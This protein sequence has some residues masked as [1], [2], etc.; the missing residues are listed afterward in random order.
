MYELFRGPVDD[1]NQ[2]CL[3]GSAQS[4][5]HCFHL[6]YIARAVGHED[7][8]REN[9]RMAAESGSYTHVASLADDAR[10]P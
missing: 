1:I 2:V 6:G 9:L 8:A 4:P 7:V 10:H 5:A 3:V